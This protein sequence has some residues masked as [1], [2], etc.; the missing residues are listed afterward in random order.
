[1]ESW[2]IIGPFW[3]IKGGKK[4]SQPPAAQNP[5][6]APACVKYRDIYILEDMLSVSSATL[7]A[8]NK[9]QIYT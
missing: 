3:V 5:G 1:M 4:A 8:D 6:N 9:C 2:V 7:F